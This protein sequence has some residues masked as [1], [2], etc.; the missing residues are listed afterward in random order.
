MA[1]S[2]ATPTTRS[3][4]EPSA[5][6]RNI[7]FCSQRSCGFFTFSSLVAKW[8]WRKRTIFSCAAVRGSAMRFSHQPRSSVRRFSRS[9]RIA[10]LIS[11]FFCAR[12]FGSISFSRFRSVLILSPSVGRRID[13]GGSILVE[14]AESNKERAACWGDREARASTCAGVPPKPALCRSWPALAR[15]QSAGSRIGSI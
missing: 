5:F 2:F 14:G 11:W 10:R 1:G 9:A 4:H 3:D 15:F 7:W 12:V 13:G 8:P 6:W